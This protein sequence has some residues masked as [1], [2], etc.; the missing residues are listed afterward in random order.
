MIES[1]NLAIKITSKRC[2]ALGHAINAKLGVIHAS[3]V[4]LFRPSK[5]KISSSN[6]DVHR[7]RY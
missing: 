4:E 7:R 1:S 3:G 6:F 2:G 5:L